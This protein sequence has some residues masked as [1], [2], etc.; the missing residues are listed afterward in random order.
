M[1]IQGRIPPNARELEDAVLGAM[2]LEREKIDLVIDVL[3]E[4]H[5]Y[6]PENQYVFRAV[7]SLYEA[8]EPI[9]LLTVTNQLRKTGEIEMAGGPYYLASLTNKVASAANI[10]YHSRILTQKFIQREL[11]RVSGEIG[12]EAYDDSRDSFQMLDDSERMLYE[13]K[14]QSL[15]K[16]YDNIGAL[17]NRALQKLEENKG[18]DFDGLTGVASGF[19]ELDR[20]T[21]G[22][23][24]SDLIILAARPAMG[25]TA[26]ALSLARN[27]AVMFNKAVAIFSLEMSDIQLVNRLICAEAEIA[28]EKIR[29][30]D[31]D[32]EEWQ[33]LH[34]KTISLS[35]SKIFI[36][37]TPQISIFDLNAK[38]RRLHSQ[39]KIDMII[40][41]YLQLIRNDDRN[42]KSREQ[43]IGF[44]SRALKGLAKELGIPIIALSQL[45]RAVE[46][47]QTKRPQLSDLRE[48]GSIEQDADIVMF[49]YRDDYYNKN[50]ASAEQPEGD[51]AIFSNVPGLTQ[52]IVAKHRNGSTGDINIKFVHQYSK[53]EDLSADDLSGMGPGSDFGSTTKSFSSKLNEFQDEDGGIT[54]N[55]FGPSVGKDPWDIDGITG[56]TGA[57]IF[58]E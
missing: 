23:Q 13:I 34:N 44:I 8:G 33:R 54:S 48:S 6:Q 57:N 28:G 41:D 9:D 1:D 32:E 58:V 20:L 3:S 40:I 36:D 26:F 42:A 52:V 47:R 17:V 39:H 30:A 21:S 12:V 51:A 53:F 2:M 31:L 19:S 5:F 24:A 14:N 7:R 56:D 10:E 16:S 45:S 29:R 50:G 15:K 25:K 27:A 49:L 11:I 18:Q 46:T 38:C 4:K 55:P 35:D 22:W 37:D 43:E